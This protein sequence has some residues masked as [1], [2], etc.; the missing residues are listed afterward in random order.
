M[1]PSI[2][3]ALNTRGPACLDRF[4]TRAIRRGVRV[5]SKHAWMA[6][7]S[8]HSWKWLPRKWISAIASCA[9]GFG[10]DPG[11]T[12][13]EVGLED[14]VHTALR[15]PEPPGRSRSGSPA[16]GTSRPPSESTPVAPAPARTRSLQRVADLA[17]KHLHP[18]PGQESGPP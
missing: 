3:N 5:S 11:T 14:G 10:P 2:K 16:G 17:Q 1:T 6:A 12:R 7:A 8:T 4:R 9:R 15:R 18:T 13:R